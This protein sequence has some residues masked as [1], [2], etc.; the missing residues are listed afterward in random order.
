MRTLLAGAAMAAAVSGVLLHAQARR[1]DPLSDGAQNVRLVGFNDLQGRE[2][3]VVTVKADQA[4]GSWVYVGHHEN[5]W[6]EKQ[7]VNPITT[8]MEWNGTSILD[9]ADPARPRL[10]WHIPNEQN[11]SSRGTDPSRIRLV[12]EISRTR[13]SSARS[14]TTFRRPTHSRPIEKGQPTVIQMNDVDIDHRG[15]AYASDRI[16]TGLFVLEYTG[17]R[18][19]GTN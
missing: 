10:V 1:A 4:N 6:D 9:I 8:Q 12:A 2:S 3:L 16:G 18:R 11:A 19:Q 7:K 14:A 5:L 15:L 13:T 17:T